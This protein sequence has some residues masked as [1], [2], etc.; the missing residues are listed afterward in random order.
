MKTLTTAIIRDE[1]IQSLEKELNQL[2][3]EKFV[4]ELTFEDLIFQNQIHPQSKIP[5]TKMSVKIPECRVNK[6]YKV[7][8]RRVWVHI[9]KT[10]EVNIKTFYVSYRVTI[11]NL[12]KENIIKKF[13][14]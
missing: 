14:N 1:K 12:M 13:L 8:D 10:S 7:K 6:I 11:L 2:M 5:Y 9:G 4:D 3:I